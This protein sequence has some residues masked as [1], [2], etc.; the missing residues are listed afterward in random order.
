MGIKEQLKEG[1]SMMGRD[2]GFKGAD[3]KKKEGYNRFARKMGY[4][5]PLPKPKLKPRKKKKKVVKYIMIKG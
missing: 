1:F 5:I 4:N 3:F 2:Y